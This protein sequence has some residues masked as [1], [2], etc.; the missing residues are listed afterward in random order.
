MLPSL[1]DIVE[2]PS[3]KL[4]FPTEVLII[5]FVSN[6]SEIF[7]PKFQFDASSCEKNY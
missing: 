7:F 6:F 3:L 2:L 4:E 5:P 1:S